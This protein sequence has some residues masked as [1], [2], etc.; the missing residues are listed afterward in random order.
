MPRARTVTIFAAAT[1]TCVAATLLSTPLAANAATI[2]TA[3]HPVSHDENPRVPVGALWTEEYF[4]SSDGSDV[5]LHADVLRPANLS[6][7]AKTPVILSVGPYFAHRG[8]TG[9]DGF[10]GTGPS[11]RFNDL[12]E[13]ADLMAR[14]YT[15]VMVDLRGFGGSTGCL[16]WVGPGEQA[17]VRAAINWSTRQSWSSGKVGMYGKSYD[18]STGLVGT[19]QAPPGLKAVVAQEPV[20]DMYNYLFSNGVRR[21]NYI[22]TPRA[23]NSI[24]GI[25]GLPDDSD[26]YRAAAAYEKTHPE[27]YADNLKDTQNPDH[28]SAYWRA[29][30]LA[31]K[32]KKSTVPLFVTQGFIENNTKPEDMQTY[33]DNHQGTERGWVGQWEHVRGNDTDGNGRLLMGRAG[34]FDEVMRYYDQ[35]L[36]GIKPKVND[37]AFAIEDS[38]GHWRAQPTWP[39]VRQSTTVALEAGSYVDDG[40]S[41]SDRSARRSAGSGGVWDMENA[42]DLPSPAGVAARGAKPDATADDNAFYTWSKPLR[43]E[44]RLTGTPRVSLQTRGTGNVLVR[45]WDVAPDG[46]ATMFDEQM[47]LVTGAKTRFDLKSTDWTLRRGHQLVVG[48]GT[49]TSFSWSDTPSNQT[50]TVKN[51]SLALDLQNT[52]HDVPTQG[53][54]SPYLNAYLDYYT[55]AWDAVARGTFTLTVPQSRG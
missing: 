15:V 8:Q 4:P 3:G 54:R 41:S 31:A 12:I 5:V 47:S 2:P 1:A 48:I 18:A 49:N 20:W 10:T 53:S 32:A 13:G 40:G 11:E 33:L 37:P 46:Q 42:P 35:Y 9:D 51:A 30:D 7:Q 26:R 45:L 38:F 19:N 14:G 6:P 28:R 22:G 52:K 21:P 44:T 25:Q 29:R 50:I 36:K 23:Y 16:D 24:A 43:Q 39:V 17:D 55:Q 34:W 27:C